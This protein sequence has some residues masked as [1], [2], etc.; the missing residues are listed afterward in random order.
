MTVNRC[1]I[2]ILLESEYHRSAQACICPTQRRPHLCIKTWNCPVIIDGKQNIMLYSKKYSI[3]T[4]KFNEKYFVHIL[5]R[6][7]V[8]IHTYYG[9][10]MSNTRE[11][12]HRSYFR[13]KKMDQFKAEL[14]PL[15]I[16]M[17][18][19]KAELIHYSKLKRLFTCFFLEPRNPLLTVSHLN[20]SHLPNCTMGN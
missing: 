3:R 4:T 9:I 16:Q 15:Q 5:R 12:R 11:R 14:Y 2:L 17:N 7:C 1:L 6:K 13:N 18:V 8:Y 19:Y 10:K 20:T